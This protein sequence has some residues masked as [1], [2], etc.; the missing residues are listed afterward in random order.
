MNR[1]R[2]WAWPRRLRNTKRMISSFV[3]TNTK[4][5]PPNQMMVH[6]AMSSRAKKS[7]NVTPMQM[8]TQPWIKGQTLR[9][10]GPSK[11]RR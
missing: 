11:G 7:I 5:M 9:H 1:L 6:R 4:A 2:Y 3:R 10:R 8:I